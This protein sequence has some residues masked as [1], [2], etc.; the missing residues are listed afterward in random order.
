MED[1]G[2]VFKL[3]DTCGRGHG[4]NR[5]CQWNLKQ[6]CAGTNPPFDYNNW[7]P[8][9]E[10]KVE[11][12][13][14]GKDVCI[15]DVVKQTA[16]HSDEL[17]KLCAWV[18]DYVKHGSL[19][20]DLFAY[21]DFLSYA[22]KHACFR[23]FLLKGGYIEKVDTWVSPKIGD[24]FKRGSPKEEYTL[25][26]WGDCLV[27]LNDNSGRRRLGIKPVKV[28]SPQ[29]ITKSEFQQICGSIPVDEMERI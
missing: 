26:S 25:N 9:E 12:K 5:P 19:E 4:Y 10:P 23:D 3:C 24:R 6:E 27:G 14:T 8:K 15:R 16:I 18:N 11:Y 1:M 7:I 21:K 20:L 22:L 17:E 2:K 29:S 28:S 13:P